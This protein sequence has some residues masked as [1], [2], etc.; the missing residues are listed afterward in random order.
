MK[1]P[2]QQRLVEVLTEH[3]RI[4]ITEAH[5]PIYDLDKNNWEIIWANVITELKDTQTWLPYSA[6]KLKIT[7]NRFLDLWDIEFEED[8]EPC[9][10]LTVKEIQ[11]E[12]KEVFEQAIEDA[13]KKLSEVLNESLPGDEYLWE[14]KSLIPPAIANPDGSGS[15]TDEYVLRFKKELIV[16]LETKGYKASYEVRKTTHKGYGIDLEYLIVEIPL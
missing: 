11:A 1:I 2:T 7:I 6:E 4:F 5:I 3:T 14:L 16:L 13:C 15:K 12:S 9:N 8:P 10:L